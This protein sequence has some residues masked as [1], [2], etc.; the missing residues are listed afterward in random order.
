MVLSCFL[1]DTYII[2]KMEEIARKNNAVNRYI[3]NSYEF[4]KSVGV[5]TKG[6]KIMNYSYW[7][8]KEIECKVYSSFDSK[9]GVRIF[10]IWDINNCIPKPDKLLAQPEIQI[11]S[12]WEK[13]YFNR[14]WGKKYDPQGKGCWLKQKKSKYFKMETGYHR[15]KV[16][17]IL[18]QN[19]N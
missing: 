3:T 13:A 1:E 11:N 8:E 6:D 19:R 15:F 2:T 5:T 4:Y 7:T 10:R 17:Y 16:R 18:S 12:S 9:A 14:I